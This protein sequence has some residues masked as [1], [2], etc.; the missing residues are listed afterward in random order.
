MDYSK[1]A[2]LERDRVEKMESQRLAKWTKT[3][4]PQSSPV[5]KTAKKMFDIE[6]TRDTEEM[7]I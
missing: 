6:V 3:Q 5:G 7:Q 1:T 4:K 2:I